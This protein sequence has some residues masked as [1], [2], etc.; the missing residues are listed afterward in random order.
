M[1]IVYEN[2]V[3]VAIVTGIDVKSA[4]RKTGDMPQLWI[5]RR[6]MHP[7]EAVK[8]GADSA[9]CGTCPLRG[10]GTGRGRACYVN[11]GNAPAVIWKKYKAGGYERVNAT[12]AAVRLAG[13]RVRLGAYGDPAVLPYELV[14]TL[15]S[16]ARGWTGY[17]HQWRTCDQRFRAVL[18]ASADDVTGRREAREAGWR[19]F[20]VVPASVVHTVDGAVECMAVRE[21]NPLQCADCLACSGT[22]GRDTVAVD[23]VIGAH[24]AGAKYVGR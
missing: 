10:D 2:D 12:D 18:M 24:G 19:S 15:I 11:I 6:D 17:T 16:L 9:I 23:I 14:E 1:M 4:N 20:Y 7:V 21:R 5:L 22:K 13:R 3:V 8:T